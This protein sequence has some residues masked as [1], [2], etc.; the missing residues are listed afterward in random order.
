M[1]ETA[2]ILSPDKRVLIPDARAGCSLAN[3]ITAGQ[4]PDYF[5]NRMRICRGVESSECA[6]LLPQKDTEFL[7]IVTAASPYLKDSYPYFHPAGNI[8][9]SFRL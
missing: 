6:C 4:R 5:S 9:H 2:K 7:G 8:P 3:S 1:A